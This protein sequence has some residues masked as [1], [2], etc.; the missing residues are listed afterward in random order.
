MID[1]PL[2]TT[3]EENPQ[4]K[5]TRLAWIKLVGREAG[6]FSSYLVGEIKK[7][8][9]DGKFISTADVRLHKLGE[10]KYLIYVNDIHSMMLTRE[11]IPEELMVESEINMLAKFVKELKDKNV[12]IQEVNIQ[13]SSGADKRLRIPLEKALEGII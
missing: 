3:Q 12:N 4:D 2:S 9:N 10:G 6:N 5:A 11:K 13:S 8:N 7:E 1:G